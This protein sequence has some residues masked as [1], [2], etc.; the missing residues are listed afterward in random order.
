IEEDLKRG[1]QQLDAVVEEAVLGRR[2]EPGPQHGADGAVAVN[3]ATRFLPAVKRG[4]R[5]GGQ[6]GIGRQQ[7][8]IRGG[9]CDH[10]FSESSRTSRTIMLSRSNA[11]TGQEVRIRFF[12]D[13]TFVGVSPVAS[14]TSAIGRP[15]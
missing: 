1:K 8:V 3:E 12:N 7:L 14:T 5:I 10:W 6:C 11:K 9:G 4:L 15:S 2:E 13:R